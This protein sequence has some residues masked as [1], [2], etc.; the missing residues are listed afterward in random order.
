METLLH[1]CK[2]LEKYTVKNLKFT[3]NG[4]GQYDRD[5]RRVFAVFTQVIPVQQI[6]R[7]RELM[8]RITL[9]ARL[10][11]IGSI[12]EVE[13]IWEEGVLRTAVKMSVGDVKAV[14][15]LRIDL[16]KRLID[17]LLFNE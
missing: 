9:I 2:D 14:L 5:V 15:G 10:L 3:L 1:I 12:E 13:E 8:Q 17:A 4:A 7:V 6:P 11:N 16:D